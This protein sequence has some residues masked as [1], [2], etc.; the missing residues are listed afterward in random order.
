MERVDMTTTYPLS[1][2]KGV[3]VDSNNDESNGKSVDDDNPLPFVVVPPVV[4]RQILSLAIPTSY[5][6]LALA[7]SDAL[8]RNNY[9][10]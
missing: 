8:A 9:Q 4:H 7:I 1:L 5:G 2:L 10:H 6:V 3:L